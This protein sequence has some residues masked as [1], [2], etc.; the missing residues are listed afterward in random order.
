MA[1]RYILPRGTI[2]LGAFI[3]I[4]SGLFVIA[5]ATQKMKPAE[6]VEKHLASIGTPSIS[7]PRGR[8]REGLR[9]IS[10]DHAARYRDLF[11][12]PHLLQQCL[13]ARLVAQGGKWR[14]NDALKKDHLSIAFCAGLLEPVECIVLL[15][16]SN[17]DICPR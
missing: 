14:F 8:M 16:Q 17:I 10:P 9:D 3:L 5:G 7:R 4:I 13:E 6:L 2:W 11:V 15:A 1:A 12:G